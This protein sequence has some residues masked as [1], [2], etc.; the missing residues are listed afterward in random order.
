MVMEQYNRIKWTHTGCVEVLEDPIVHSVQILDIE[1]REGQRAVELLRKKILPGVIAHE[2][3]SFACEG[4]HVQ[5]DQNQATLLVYSCT[6][7]PLPIFVI[8]ME[9]LTHLPELVD[10][11]VLQDGTGRKVIAHIHKGRQGASGEALDPLHGGGRGVSAERVQ[12]AVGR[13]GWDCLLQHG[14][15]VLIRSGR[16]VVGVEPGEVRLEG[17]NDE[18]DGP[19]ES[20]LG[21]AE[22]HRLLSGLQHVSAG[23]GPVHFQPHQQEPP[24]KQ[25]DAHEVHRAHPKEKGQHRE[26]FHPTHTHTHI[27]VTHTGDT[28]TGTIQV[29]LFHTKAKSQ[30]NNCL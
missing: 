17:V 15:L 26:P 23:A 28:S 24:H 27:Q 29:H 18:E 7:E 8:T 21:A 13:P 2:D 22:V 12:A 4:T 16:R 30:R 10:E 5:N 11:V 19:A 20:R 1:R 3:H 6:F 9:L 14:Q 25:V